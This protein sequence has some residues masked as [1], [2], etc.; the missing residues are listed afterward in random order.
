[1]KTHY[2]VEPNL[3]EV[4]EYIGKK[5]RCVADN[6]NSESNCGECIF[7]GTMRCATI[8]CASHERYDER[9]VHFEKVD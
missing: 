8:C 5:A 2:K 3:G 7:A 1:M 4:F 6:T 9:D